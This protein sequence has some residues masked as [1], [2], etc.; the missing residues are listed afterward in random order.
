MEQQNI[1]GNYL[2]TFSQKLPPAN[3]IWGK[4]IFSQASVILFPGGG[5]WLPSMHHRSHDQGVLHPGEVCIQEG[6]HPDGGRGVE[7]ILSDTMV[8]GQQA[9]GTLPTGLHSC[10]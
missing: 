1:F 9:G 4:V 6:L 10:F 5:E 7:Q 3:E 2:D 8:Y